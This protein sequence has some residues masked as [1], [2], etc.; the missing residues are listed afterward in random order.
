MRVLFWYCEHFTWQP[1]MKTLDEVEDGTPGGSEKAVVAFVHVEPKDAEQL[2]KVETKL[3]KNVKWLTRKWDTSRVVLHSFTH[4][5]EEKAPAQVAG[6]LLER[7]GVRLEAV[8]LEV[9]HTP[10]GHFL[11]LQLS[12]PGHPLARVFKEF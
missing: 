5:S 12:A 11:D 8:E 4:L 9:M 2:S 3:V 7:V 6:A 10:Y 1:A